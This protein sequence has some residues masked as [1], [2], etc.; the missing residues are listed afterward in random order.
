MKT[1]LSLV[2]LLGMSIFPVP[3]AIP[4]EEKFGDTRFTP[5]EGLQVNWPLS[6]S[7]QIIQGHAVPIYVGL[8]RKKYY[9]LGRIDVPQ[10]GGVQ[11]V[12]RGPS[13]DLLFTEWSRQ[14]DCANSARHHGGNAVLVTGDEK[15]LKAFNVTKEDL[16]KTAPLMEH[17]DKLVLAIQ[18]ESE[19]VGTK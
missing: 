11:I 18:F 8:P 15:I 5:F 17:K 4:A 1:L 2:V 9:I 6:E 19:V 16:E 7:A 13:D 14:R 12:K 3:Q 10:S